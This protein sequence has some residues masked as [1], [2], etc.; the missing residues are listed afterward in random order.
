MQRIAV[1]FIDKYRRAGNFF[2]QRK[3]NDVGESE[4]KMFVVGN[5]GLGGWDGMEF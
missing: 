1:I 4:K 2:R 5:I 3:R